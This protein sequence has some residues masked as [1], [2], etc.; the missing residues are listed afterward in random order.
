MN[1]YFYERG[2]LMI[3]ILISR[4]TRIGIVKRRLQSVSTRLMIQI[5]DGGGLL[6][7]MIEFGKKLLQ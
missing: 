3:M 1:R 4:L 6:V 5:L 7:G 2:V